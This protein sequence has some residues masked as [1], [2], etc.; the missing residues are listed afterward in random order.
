MIEDSML[1]ASEDATLGSVMAKAERILP[2]SSGCSHCVLCSG[3][4]DR[5]KTSML[6][7]SGAEQLNVSGAMGERPMISQR[8]AYSRFVRPAPHSLSGRKRF[9]S[10]GLQLLHDGRDLPARRPGIELLVEHRLVG[11][12]VLVHEVGELL[13]VH[14]RLLRV[15]EFHRRAP[16]WRSRHPG[17][18]PRFGRL[19]KY[20]QA[21]QKRP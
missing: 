15:F 9:Q 10:R 5:S 6:P 16:L 8:G 21:D 7:V 13:H 19:G 11:I 12:D 14:L 4:P 20:A 2:A 18:Y 1:V 3:V 17:L